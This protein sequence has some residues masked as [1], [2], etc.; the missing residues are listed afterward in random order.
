MKV[1]PAAYFDGVRAQRH[2]ASVVLAGRSVKVVGHEIDA[3]YDA[4]SLRFSPRIANTP[5]WLYLPDGGRC[6]VSDN[7]AIDA[8]ASEP[9]MLR[10]VRHW[11]ARPA[12]AA[13]AVGLVVGAL[14]LLLDFGVPAVAG[15]VA[16][17]IPPAAE[18]ALGRETLAKL[19]RFVLRPSRLL[20]LRRE[21]LRAEFAALVARGGARGIRYRL[22][23]RYSPTV[24]ANAFA[25][26]SG[27]IVVTDQMVKLAEDDDEVLAVLAHELGHVAHRDAMRQLLQG[28]A[29]ALVIAA[30]TGDI[31]STTS[32][33]AAAPTVLLRAKYSRDDER[34]ADRFAIALLRK[35][36][37]NPAN[38]A[39][40]LARLE[41]KRP[42]R[43][44]FPGFLASHPATPEREA[45]AL[46]AATRSLAAERRLQQARRARERASRPPAPPI[47]A[48]QNDL[49]VRRALRASSAAALLAGDVAGLEAQSSTDLRERARTP[50]GLWKLAFFYRGI[51]DA[52][53]GTIRSRGRSAVDRLLA[54]ADAWHRAYPASPSAEVARAV[55]L[56]Q[57]A[58]SI[59]G[60]TTAVRVPKRAW[61]PFRQAVAETRAYLESVKPQASADPGWYCVMANVALAQGW[62]RAEYEAFVR[63]LLARHPY[64]YQGLFCAELYLL[65]RW[66]YRNARDLDAFAEQAVAR[67]RSE[68]GRSVYARIYWAAIGTDPDPAVVGR[69]FAV[70]PKMKAGFDDLV[71]R[72]PDA[73]NLNHY[74]MYA[75]FAGDRRELATLMPR[76]ERMPL[77]TAWPRGMYDECRDWA[78]AA[79]RGL[80]RR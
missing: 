65:P 42:R 44:A 16:Q 55:I 46:A 51:G 37:I 30:V 73:W 54:V 60:T 39:A 14:W 36:D 70:W 61:A 47:P 45:L 18:A 33:A 28:S 6:A 12:Y 52:V 79:P 21:R 53:R 57:R 17:R 67:T 66:Y 22:E 58:W 68:D 4:A 31:A 29:S 80:G 26:P 76:V 72:Y 25:L 48:A 43:G 19:D 13:L 56:E 35:G 9:A 69:D 27:I 11:E 8:F 32:I 49:L 34:D 74:A 23:F 59:R 77:P 1:L 40:I 10:V 50:S 24:G 63:E 15:R 5:R 75:C 38:F 3:S 62:Q 7:D 41:K 64:Y 2:D 20:P 71:A 78:L